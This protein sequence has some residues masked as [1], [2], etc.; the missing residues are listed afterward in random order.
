MEFSR[1]DLMKMSL[2]GGVAL[3]LPLEKAARG[4][5]LTANR[6]AESALPAPFSVPFTTPPVLARHSWDDVRDVYRVSMEPTQVEIVPGLPTTMWGYNGHVPGPTIYA[7]RG[8]RV[9]ARFVNNLPSRHPALGYA[10]W[11]SVHLHGSASLPQYDGYASDVTNPGQWKDYEYPNYQPARTLWYHDHGA[12]HTAENVGMGLA[13]MYVLTD[14]LERG[15]PIPH[16][17]FDVPLIVTDAMFNADGSLL[18]DDNDGDGF[19]GDVVLVNGRPWP[20]MQ[21]KRRKYRFR[22]LNASASRSYNFS[23][24]TGDPMKV[25]ATDGGLMPSP[26]AV[27]SFRHG[28]AERYEVV[29]DFAQ[30]PAG[31]RVVLRNASPKNNVNWTHT[32]K[33]MAFDVVG[34]SVSKVGNSVPSQLFPG[35][36]TM[37]LQDPGGLT[38]RKFTF[39]RANG[40]WRINGGSWEDVVRSGFTKVLA[41]PARD[42]LEI[43]ELSNP[44]GGWHHPAHIHFVDFKILSRNGRP[45]KPH[46]LGAKDVVFLGE[47]ET[48]R[49]LVKFDGGSGKYMIHCHNLVHEDH[50]MMGQFEIVDPVT[51]APGPFDAPAE[52][53]PEP[54]M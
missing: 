40:Q 36:P 37:A 20:V 12:H 14:D 34:G 4:S 28:N 31:T 9:R 3:A 39:A 23:L 19:Y 27:R 29:V 22:I 11:T 49:L 30:Y 26:R 54:E 1:R 32:D 44:S 50:D 42:A 41:D 10:P 43:W 13:G 52:W 5:A 15:L 18:F 45:P 2:M 46:E 33:V 21:V 24:S 38:V 51:P 7:S 8:R 35:Q 48:V 17:E 6:I 16:G 25:I 53:L 47:N